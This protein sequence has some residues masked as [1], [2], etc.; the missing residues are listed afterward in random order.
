MKHLERAIFGFLI[1][2]LFYHMIVVG[3]VF[4]AWFWET[5]QF[6]LA[7]DGIRA[8]LVLA[9]AS[10]VWMKQLKNFFNDRWYEVI[11]LLILIVWAF[12][13]SRYVRT[14]FSEMLIGYKYGIHFL[15]I[16]LS[17]V[18]VG[19]TSLKHKKKDMKEIAELIYRLIAFIIVF[20]AVYQGVKM[21]MPDLFLNFWYWPIGD[22]VVWVN[23]PLRYRTGPWWFPRL[24]GLFAWPNNYGYF[25]VWIFSFLLIRSR[26]IWHEDKENRYLVAWVWALFVMSLLFTLSRWAF[27]A[28]FFQ[29]VVLGLLAFKNL[30]K[31]RSQSILLGLWSVLMLF[32][33]VIWLSYLKAWSTALHL[34]ARVSWREAFVQNP[35][36][37][38]LW[39][40]WPSVHH[41]WVY[42]PESQFLQILLDIW[43]IWLLF[44][45]LCRKVLLTP[46]FK[47]LL[48][49]KSI[50][51][52]PLY[53]LLGLW[54][55]WVMIEWFFLHV[56]EDSMV[57]YLLLVSFGILLGMSR[58]W[59]D[60][61][62]NLS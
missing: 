45:I 3:A 22:Y 54:I 19:H 23:P 37:Y 29:L 12:A 8:I 10:S 56:W 62:K 33:L 17:A 31:N 27:V 41:D 11:L 20:G 24:Q 30:L 25:L 55:L 32:G 16:T 51:D 60:D 1:L 49:E 53:S 4:G 36:G 47:H 59:L 44:W 9:V 43:V 15:V 34:E 52:L 14:P 6:A 5:I 42:L 57:N 7:R 46:S 2:V 39:T 38:G 21:L 18:F 26:H 35:M 48:V 13:Y 50:R 58:E 40:S 28:V 61:V